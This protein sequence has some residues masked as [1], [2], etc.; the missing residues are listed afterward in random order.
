MSKIGIILGS[1][2]KG[3]SGEA[4]ANWVYDIAKARN[5]AGFECELLD[6]KSFNVPLLESEVVPGAA[7]KQYDDANVQ[8]W[9]DAIDSCDAFVFVT[10]E[11]NHSVPGAF[12]NAFDS[13]GSEWANKPVAFVSY[14]FAGGIRAVEAWRVAVANFSMKQLRNQVDINM[15][16]DYTDGAFTPA[17]F[18][19][20][21]MDGVLGEVEA[22]I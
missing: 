22:A 1:I 6:L 10:P 8:A 13:L 16:T 11:Y 15:I 18:K 20:G 19:A 2:R 21:M 4:V 7:N 3:R 5:A 12:K 17:E 14:G 9:S